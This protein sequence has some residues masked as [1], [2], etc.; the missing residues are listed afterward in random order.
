LG[1]GDPIREDAKK[2][3]RALQEA[4]WELSLCSGDHPEI[5][6]LVARQVGIADASGAVSPEAKAK[7]VVDLRGASSSEGAKRVVMVGDGVN[8]AAALASA[9]VGIAVHG[10]AEASLEA[11]DVYLTK[12]GVDPIVKLVSLASHTMRTIHMSLVFS[13]CY[14]VLVA[15]L[16]MSGMINALIAAVIMPISSLTVVA[17]STR[18][19]KGD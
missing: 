18:K 16:A 11:A 3:I 9:D 15:G 6:E 19:W 8:D 10:G 12:Q 17:M 7:R 4:H 5:A 13:I 1:I 2:S 14:N